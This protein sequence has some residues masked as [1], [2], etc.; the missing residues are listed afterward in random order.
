MSRAQTGDTVR[1]HYR[2]TLSDGAQ[3]DSSHGGEPLEFKLGEGR[4]IPGF[5]SAVEGMTPGETCT[6]LIVSTEAYGPRR[7]ELVAQVQ[8]DQLPD[9]LSLEVGQTLQ[10][11][12]PEGNPFVVHVSAMGDEQVTLDA[13]HPLA[14]KDLNFEIELVEIL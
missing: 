5:E 4:L 13:N 3:F 10:M 11:K 12:D 8:R 7:D 14:G 6:T 9:D 2:G 1:V